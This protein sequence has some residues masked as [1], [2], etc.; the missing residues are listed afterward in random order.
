MRERF[1]QRQG[2]HTMSPKKFQDLSR[3]FKDLFPNFPEPK[4]TN[5]Q[6]IFIATTCSEL[7]LGLWFKENKLD[8]FCWKSQSLH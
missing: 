1:G 4:I 6:Q 3:T 8:K 2:S 7:C 5:R